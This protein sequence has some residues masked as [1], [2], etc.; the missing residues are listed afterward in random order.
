MEWEQREPGTTTLPDGTTFN[1]DRGAEQ[2][3][4]LGPSK[5]ALPLGDAIGPL[6]DR[7]A[8]RKA[9]DE[10]FIDDGQLVCSPE[11]FDPWLRAFDVAIGRFGASRGQGTNVKSVARL[12]CP[13]G[14]VDEFQGWD[15]EYVRSSCKVELPNSSTEVLGATIG[16]DTDIQDAALGK[17]QKVQ[18]KRRVIESLD[19]TPTELI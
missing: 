11:T 9:C 2:G 18:K 5:S 17:C 12:V 14:R 13:P 8:L 10:W 6:C 3:E 19:H 16:E 7:D 15:T 4:P 1:F